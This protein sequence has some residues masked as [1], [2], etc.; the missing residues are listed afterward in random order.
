[1]N[2]NIKDRLREFM[3]CN[4]ICIG[5]CNV[6]TRTT[7]IFPDNTTASFQIFTSDSV[8]VLSGDSPAQDGLIMMVLW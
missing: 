7:N 4:D 1:M 8:I 2:K 5:A 6:G 3:P